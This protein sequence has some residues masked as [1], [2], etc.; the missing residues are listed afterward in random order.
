[1]ALMVQEVS[2]WRYLFNVSFTELNGRPKN[3]CP[4]WLCELIYTS[5]LG[6]KKRRPH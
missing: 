5:N 3:T 4:H 1:M 2:C 6:H